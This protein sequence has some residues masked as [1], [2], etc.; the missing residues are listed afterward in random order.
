MCSLPDFLQI[1]RTKG[2]NEPSE[3]AQLL[4]KQ[5]WQ[6]DSAELQAM[7]IMTSPS[8]ASPC[9][10][11]PTTRG[12]V[13]PMNLAWLPEKHEKV[14]ERFNFDASVSPFAQAGGRTKYGTD[15]IA[16]VLSR[17]SCLF[18]ISSKNPFFVSPKALAMTRRGPLWVSK[19]LLHH[20]L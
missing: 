5:P 11:L 9:L 14:E 3:I 7:S 12:E 6:L 4:C 15:C 19:L 17:S 18:G 16:D 8:L 20:R 13:V 2:Q 10:R 1:S